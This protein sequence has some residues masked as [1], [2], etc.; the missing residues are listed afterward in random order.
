MNQLGRLQR[1]FLLTFVESFSGVLLQR[2]LYFYTHDVLG[3]DR[4]KNLWLALLSGVAYVIGAVASHPVSKRSGER[5]LLM[6]TLGGALSMHLLLMQNAAPWALMTA[7]PAVALFQGFKWPVIESF[8]SAGLGPKDLVR[9]LGRFNVVWAASVPIGLVMAGQLIGASYP[10]AL[11]A[12]AAASNA[13]SIAVAIPLPARPEHLPDEH[14]DRPTDAELEPLRE[15][16]VSARWCMLSSYALMFLLAPLMPNVFAALGVDL[17]AATA[18]AGLLDV[19]RLVAFAALGAS[20]GWRGRGWP[21]L[22]CVIALPIGFALV[23]LG[24]S[25]VWVLLGEVTFGLAA[26]FVYTASL[27]YAL[28]LKN[29]SVDAGGAH[30]GLIGTGFALGPIAGLVGATASPWFGSPALSL[31]VCSAPMTLSFALLS[32]WPLRHSALRQ[33]ARIPNSNS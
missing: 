3:F 16:L 28:L 15:L 24:K 8:L 32:L 26:G 7:F 29:A 14:P 4:S 2:G 11:F 25:L 30:E 18:A 19:A 21:H 27:Y 33:R 31:L 12:A 5:R 22:A 6:V 23:L 10:G 1:I 17:A 9:T 20:A 13:L